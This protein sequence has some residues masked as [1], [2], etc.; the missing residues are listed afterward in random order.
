MTAGAGRDR[1]DSVGA[2]LDR[3][4]CEAVVDDVV[5]RDSAPAEWTASLSSM[6]AP[7]E[8]MT[9]GTFH[10]AQT[11]MSCSNRSFDR[12]TIWLT[13]KGAAGRSG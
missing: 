9:I 12:W 5:K 13:A 6:R 2:F 3:L 1:N 10:F 8:V 11:S 4:A 7:S